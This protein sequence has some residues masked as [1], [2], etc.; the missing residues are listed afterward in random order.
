MLLNYFPLASSLNL[1]PIFISRYNRLSEVVEQMTVNIVKDQL[2]RRT[3]G[4]V[5]TKIFEGFGEALFK[6]FIAGW[7]PISTVHYTRP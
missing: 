4:R 5:A 3:Q 2:N 1:S 7:E 6:E